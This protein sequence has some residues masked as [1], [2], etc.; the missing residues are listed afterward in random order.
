MFDVVRKSSGGKPVHQ[1]TQRCCS[2]GSRLLCR[3]RILLFYQLFR[4]GVF[5]LIDTLANFVISLKR[6]SSSQLNDIVIPTTFLTTR[7]FHSSPCHSSDNLLGYSPM[8]QSRPV[9][10]TSQG[11]H[12]ISYTTI[13][14]KCHSNF[15]NRSES[16]GGGV[17][18]QTYPPRE[19]SLPN[20]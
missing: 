9:P 2:R 7:L 16:V 19:K 4:P 8:S 6:P 12:N 15:W 14:F 1:D 5:E 20:Y 13:K 17:W 3:R 10:T 18:A 11:R